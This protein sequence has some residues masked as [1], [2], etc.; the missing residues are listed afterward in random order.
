[1]YD[2]EVGYCQGT[3]FVVGLL[4]LHLPEEECFHMTVTIMRDYKSVFHG[5]LCCLSAMTVLV[6]RVSVNKIGGR[7]L[8]FGRLVTTVVVWQ[9]LEH[10]VYI[11]SGSFISCDR[12]DQ[13]VIRCRPPRLTH[14]HLLAYHPRLRGLFR[15]NM[16]DMPLRLF[17]LDGLLQV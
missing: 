5:Q 12:Q 14:R 6:E 17:Q 15:S 8:L 13:C 1:M 4:I 11:A 10:H 7:R 16:A 9:Q 3:P 2:T